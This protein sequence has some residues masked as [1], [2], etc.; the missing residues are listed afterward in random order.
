[1][2]SVRRPHFHSQLPAVRDRPWRNA[3]PWRSHDAWGILISKK[4]LRSPRSSRSVCSGLRTDVW[5]NLENRLFG[6]VGAGGSG[7]FYVQSPTCCKPSGSVSPPPRG[8][9]GQGREDRERGGAAPSDLFAIYFLFQVTS[10]LK[11]DLVLLGSGKGLVPTGCLV[12]TAR[13]RFRPGSPASG[14]QSGLLFAPHLSSRCQLFSWWIIPSDKGLR[15]STGFSGFCSV[16]WVCA[17]AHAQFMQGVKPKKQST[18]S[19][20]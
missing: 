11:D 18:G 19:L 5:E 20:D 3:T 16:V 4:I 13:S 10:D 17:R 2:C 12:H 8:G 15:S 1:M 14:P 9:Q 7:T 6:G